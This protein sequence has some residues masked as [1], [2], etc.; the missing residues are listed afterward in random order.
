[1]SPYMSLLENLGESEMV[2][3]GVYEDLGR[4]SLLKGLLGARVRQEVRRE[5]REEILEKLLTVSGTAWI[6]L[7]EEKVKQ[8]IDK[9]HGDHMNK[10]AKLI[11]SSGVER[12]SDAISCLHKREEFR[13]E[14]FKFFAE[15]YRKRA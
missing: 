4:G 5:N 15:S 9:T 10:L 1:M 8:E 14:L 13:E 6:D 2:D 7:L 11:V 3:G 12:W